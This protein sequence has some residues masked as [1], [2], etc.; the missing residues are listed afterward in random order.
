MTCSGQGGFLEEGPGEGKER[1]RPLGRDAGS[2]QVIGGYAEGLTEGKRTE[3]HQELSGRGNPG[4]G[5][6]PSFHRVTSHKTARSRDP[7][8]QIKADSDTTTTSCL[9]SQALP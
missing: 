7:G 3:S 1:R 8:Q 5:R 2:S 6:P 4:A 9:P